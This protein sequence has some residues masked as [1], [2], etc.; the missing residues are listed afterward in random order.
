MPDVTDHNAP[1]TLSP[2]ESTTS[3]G[4]GSNGKDDLIRR[5][6]VIG[7]VANY[8]GKIVALAAGF[9]LTPFILHEV[10]AATYGIWVLAGVVVQYGTLLDLGMSN[11][12]IKYVAEHR[13]LDDM[14]LAGK[15]V[16][17]VL[18]LYTA[19]GVLVAVVIVALAPLFGEAFRIP[20]DQRGTATWL[21]II[22][23]INLG[24][25]LPC[26]IT[27]AVLRGLQRFGLVNILA[28]AGT[29]VGVACTITVLLLGGGILAV[30]LISIPIMLLLQIPAVIF[31]K[32]SAPEL[33]LGWRGGSRSLARVVLTYSGPT[34][35]IQLGG[36][37]QSRMDAIVIAALKPVALVTPYSFAL[38]LSEIPQILT[39]QFMKLIL[40][41]ASELHA[42]SDRARLRGLFVTGTRLTLALFLPVAAVMVILAPQILAAWV[43]AQYSPYAYLVVILTAGVGIDIALWPAGSILQGMA[44]Q[45]AFAIS[46]LCTAAANLALSIILLQHVGLA[47]VALGTLIPAAFEAVF[48]LS[49]TSRILIVGVVSVLK[50][51]LLPPL[52][53]LIPT[54]FLLL[55][56]AQILHSPSLLL[57][58]VISA[59]AGLTYAGG[60]VV[61]GASAYERRAYQGLMRDALRYART[62][63]SASQ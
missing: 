54:C 51:I 21:I 24:L 61:F 60:Y 30:A 32:R 43:G 55:V 56:F 10:G 18:C 15:L 19:L 7:T 62:R 6:V 52:I 25:T 57:L 12:V 33:R 20:V 45:R 26:T 5:R 23:G 48:V 8:G 38:R 17:T 14:E 41:L 1:S 53:P 29:L 44:R 28:V 49:W 13:A 39:D 35:F 40:P 46:A 31:V 37:V 36:T 11:A 58:L 4:A 50:E 63:A 22:L 34:L 27:S 59:A 9:F 2:T 3:I 16:A 47:G 42:E